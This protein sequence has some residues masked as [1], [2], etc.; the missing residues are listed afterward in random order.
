[1]GQRQKFRINLSKII[2]GK[3]QDTTL[4]ANDI[5]FVPDS[6]QKIVGQRA[7]DASCIHFLGMAHLGPLRRVTQLRLGD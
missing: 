4:A 3:A 6:K 7:T 1:M 2:S 5:L